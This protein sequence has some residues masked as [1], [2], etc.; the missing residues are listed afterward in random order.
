MK[1]T[2]HSLGVDDESIEIL[3]VKIRGQTKF[4]NVVLNVCY[5]LPDQNEVDETVFRYL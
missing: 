5:K 3:G 4:R 1:H 2:E